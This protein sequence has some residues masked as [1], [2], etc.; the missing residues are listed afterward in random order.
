ML[1]ETIVQR[2]IITACAPTIAFVCSIIGRKF[3]VCLIASNNGTNSSV[4]SANVGFT[5]N[6]L[7]QI[8]Y[9]NTFIIDVG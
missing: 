9:K 8:L 6:C 7:R 3:L 4:T 1:E 2:L 5:Q